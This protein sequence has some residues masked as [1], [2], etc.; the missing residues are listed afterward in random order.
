LKEFSTIHAMDCRNENDLLVS[1]IT[2]WRVQ[3]ITLHPQAQQ[4]SSK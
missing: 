3:K 1:E 4:I 2:S